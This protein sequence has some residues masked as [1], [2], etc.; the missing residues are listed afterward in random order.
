MWCSTSG[1]P[2][3]RVRARSGDVAHGRGVTS[4][5]LR[6]DAPGSKMRSVIRRPALQG[7]LLLAALVAVIVTAGP[8]SAQSTSPSPTSGPSVNGQVSGA[9]ASGST[10][11]IRVDGTMPGG[12]QALHLL[13][14]SIMSGNQELD[15][16]RFDIEDNKLIVGEQDLIVGTGAVAT[17]AYLR[18]SGADVIVTT[19]GANISFEV[20]A[21]VVK[22][23]PEDARF[24]LGVVDDLRRVGRG[25]PVAGSA[26]EWRDHLGDGDRG[27]PDRAPCRRRDR[28]SLRF[29]APAPSAALAL[30]HDR[31]APAGRARVAP[32]THDPSQLRRRLYATVAAKLDR[33]TREHDGRGLWSDLANRVDPAEYRPHLRDDI[34]VKA[35]KLRWGNDYAMI[36]NPTDLVHY[37]L[38]PEDVEA[39]RAHGRDPDREGDRRR[40]LPGVRRSRARRGRGSG[41]TASDRELPD[42]ALRR[43]DGDRPASG[44]SHDDGEDEGPR[45]RQDALDRLDGSPQARRLALSSWAAVLLHP[46]G[47]GR[48]A[49]A[50]RPGARGVRGRLRRAIASISGA[51]LP[52]PRR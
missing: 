15:Q 33:D 47:R 42:R 36:A 21:H 17:S 26:R 34:E 43:H 6:P 12:W 7:S 51:T 27:D 32:P 28:E 40:V 24:V 35:F 22:T 52:R 23:I 39:P 8:A 30:R 2:Y 13:E 45:V 41:P 3:V 5:T 50:C 46:G 11:T 14:A 49:R 29:Q 44:P 20:D 25:H 48:R 38:R 16:L 31:S 19:G 18:V 1:E 4:V 10:L 9:L 37:Q